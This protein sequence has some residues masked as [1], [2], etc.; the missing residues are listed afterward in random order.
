MVLYEK[1]LKWAFKRIEI[2]LKED[3]KSIV[4]TSPTN[5]ESIR[6]NRIDKTKINQ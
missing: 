6:T 2:K 5:N 3:I 1:Y 4:L